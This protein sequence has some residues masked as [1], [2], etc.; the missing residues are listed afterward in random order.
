MAGDIL[1]K[2]R[3]LP[4]SEGGRR[5]PTPAGQFGCLFVVDETTL[6]C[7]LQVSETGSLMP[8]DEVVVPVSFLDRDYAERFVEVG[9]HFKLREAR[10]I[11]NGEVLE[12]NFRS[13]AR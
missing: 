9:T 12:V 1:V 2:L 13:D 7:R 3:L 5:S 6:D 10:V 11:G 8:G 4:T